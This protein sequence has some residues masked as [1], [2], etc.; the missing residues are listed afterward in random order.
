MTC[1]TQVLR[2]GLALTVGA[3][4]IGC[5]APGGPD[6]I[7]SSEF[8]SAMNVMTG[9]ADAGVT[10]SRALKCTPVSSSQFLP[11]RAAITAG[12]AAAAAQPTYFTADLFNLFK[13]VCGGCHVENNLGGF[14]VTA[15]N[16]TTTVTATKAAVIKS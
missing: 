11:A 3:A 6:K 13:S 12:V 7:K 8:P 5:T 2:V 10:T 4:L 14:F 9:G 16:F 1:F 15:D